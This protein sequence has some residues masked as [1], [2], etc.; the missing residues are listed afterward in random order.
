MALATFTKATVTTY[1]FAKGNALPMQHEYEPNQI[2]GLSGGRSKKTHSLGDTLEKWSIKLNRITKADH[3]LL[4]AFFSN[5]L[6]DWQA[7][8]FTWTDEL[9]VARTVTLWDAETLQFPISAGLFRNV[10]FT[11]RTEP[12]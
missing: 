6:I 10:S 9:S 8:P 7:N 2:T 11:L 4:V 5:A 1:T 12:T 3:D